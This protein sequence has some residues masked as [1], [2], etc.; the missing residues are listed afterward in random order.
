MA[1]P[2][3]TVADR[4]FLCFFAIEMNADIKGERQELFFTDAA[5][6]LVPCASLKQ[7]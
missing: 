2:H 7:D 4:V 6:F 3:F 1:A 5:N